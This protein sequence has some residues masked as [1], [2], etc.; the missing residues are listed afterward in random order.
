V[1]E[2]DD[3]NTVDPVRNDCDEVIFCTTNVWAVIAPV[4]SALE[5]VM[6][7]LTFNDPVT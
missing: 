4:I 7:L 1:L 5:A 2:S 3:P 6:L